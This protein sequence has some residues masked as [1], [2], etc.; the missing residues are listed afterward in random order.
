M[1]V[2]S[3]KQFEKNPELFKSLRQARKQVGIKNNAGIVD[4]V[5]GTGGQTPDEKACDQRELEK[6]Y[7]EIG[8]D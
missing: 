3:K 5:I 2:I 1:T 6:L 4:V 7:R 8:I